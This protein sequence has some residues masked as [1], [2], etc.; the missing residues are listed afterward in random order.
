MKTTFLSILI[1]VAAFAATVPSETSIHIR[2]SDTIDSSKARVGDTFAA[3]VSES[4]EVNGKTVIPRGAG[5]TVKLLDMS[6][7][8]KFAG[9]TGLGVVLTEIRVEGKRIA[10]DTSEVTR[11]SGS[12]AKN[13]ALKTGVGAGIGAA[14]GAIAGGGRGAAIGA[15][16]GGAA[17]AG[18]QVFTDG[19]K[20]QIPS[21]TVL[22]FVLRANTIVP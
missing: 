1:S 21:E 13:T 5:A 6:K 9:K 22:T 18:S 20:V 7:S 19:K 10:M 17:G 8:G 2:L 3:S 4:V 11:T 14:I 15:G 16:A 12:Q